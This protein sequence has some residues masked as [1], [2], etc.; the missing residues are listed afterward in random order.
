MPKIETTGKQ[1]YSLL[2][3]TLTDSEMED[4]FPVAKA[5]LD[6]HEGDTIKIELNDT[7]R[8]DL[9][10][11]AGIA[12]QLRSYW[13]EGE[14][15][16]DFFSTKDETFDNEGRCLIVDKSVAEVRPYSIGFAVKGH[17][18]SDE[19]L[20]ALIQSQEKLCFNFGRKRKTIAMGIYRS[21]LIK[22]PVH[23]EGVNPDT[24][25]FVPLGMTES[26][27]LRQMCSD[28]PKGKDYGYIVADK[29]VFPYLRDD[30]GD[31]LSFPPVIN[32]DRIGSVKVGDNALFVELSGPNLRDLLLASSIMACDMADL[33]FQILPVKVLFPEE[34]EFGSELTVPYYFQDPISCPL[35]LVHK[36]LGEKL[37]GDQAILALKKMGIFALCSENVLYATVPEYRNDFLHA[38]DL[39]EDIMIGYGLGNFKPEM[40]RDFTVGRISAV[41]EFSRKVKDIMVGLGYQEMVYNYLGSKREY[42]ENMHVDGKDYIYISNPM[43]ENFEVVRP[44]I[45][46]SLLESESVSGH[47][48]FPH[49]IFEI[50][51][52]AYLCPADNS[53]TTTRNNLG[54][55][56]S[57]SVMGFNEASSYV[58]T[59]MYFVNKE[60][61]LGALEND[62]RFIEGRCA[63]ILCNGK[64]LGVF[65]EV[66]PA[67]LES[68]GCSMPTIACEL[69]L[70]SIL[71]E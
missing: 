50:G 22:Y 58:N 29:K 11:A 57:N 62:P 15:L 10:S 16:Y 12:R 5:E 49:N 34:T 41:E 30:N 65:G 54:F 18:V 47:A 64:K 51:K 9:W 32:S 14:T 60:Y 7:N 43:S 2:G 48:T 69:D 46:P 1:F 27:T 26:M 8:P 67:V 33:G 40:P 39:V 55:L 21:D 36:T 24:T 6:G 4:I 31:A 53:G 71:G 28:H 13:G 17:T 20:V 61:T 35:S 63:V 70:D 59:I 45:I 38:V 44:S 23:Y 37:T 68:W 42:V 25:S 52:V 3:K 56:A 19:D 66:H